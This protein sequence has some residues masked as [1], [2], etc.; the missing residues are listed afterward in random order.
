MAELNLAL[1]RTKN[2]KS[3]GMDNLNTEL[4]TYGGNPLQ[5][6]LLTLFNDIWKTRHIPDEREAGLV[7]NIHKKGSKN[8]CKNYKGITLLPTASKHFQ[9]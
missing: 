7:I 6:T 5:E 9:I 4:F 8:K 3:T 2:I 1:I